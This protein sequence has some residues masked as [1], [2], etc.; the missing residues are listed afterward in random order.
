[1]KC[2][3]SSILK[4]SIPMNR[5]AIVRKMRHK[6]RDRESVALPADMLIECIE[7]RIYA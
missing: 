4:T 6:V 5:G 7:Y 3:N 1:M 2:L